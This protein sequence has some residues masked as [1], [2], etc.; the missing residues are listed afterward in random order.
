MNPELLQQVELLVGSI[1]VI[2]GVFF[3]L[4]LVTNRQ[5]QPKATIF[6][7]IYLFAFSLRIGKS[8]FH[9]FFEIDA[10]VRTAFLTTL[11]CVG[12]SIWLYT[13]HLTK[14]NPKKVVPN[15]VHFIP[16]FILLSIS[17][18]IPNNGSQIFGI[19]YDFLIVHMFGY[20]IFS[21][22]WL[23]RL[24]DII[25]SKESIAIRNWL[26]Y[27]LL[28]NLG[29]I[30]LY[31]LISEVIIPFYIGI[32]FLFS[33]VVI[34]LSFWALKNPSLFKIPLKKYK[35][36]TFDNEEVLQ[37]M[38][39]LKTYMDTEKP[40]LDPEIS[41]PKLSEKLEV[42]TK[43]LSQII[44]QSEALNYSQFISKYRVQEAQ[45]LMKTPSY[46]DK[47]IA[48]IAYDCGFNSISSF[49]SSFKKHAQMT[50]IAYRKSVENH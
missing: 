17:W 42:S 8:L 39:K 6:L 12:P 28:L 23:R 46:S 5:N 11:L 19:F 49:N 32:S 16:F 13:L 41:L 18:A 34:A 37:Q 26:Y 38:E 2:L 31:F 30:I 14:T 9:N 22:L 36:S 20:I 24:K 33:I 4:F 35:D 15:Y 45:R 50:P 43:E 1:G 48:A 44:N 21:I 29:F 40:Y 10:V 25:S 47:T 7:A 3:A 27:F